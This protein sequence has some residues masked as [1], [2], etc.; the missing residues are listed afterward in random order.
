M[1]YLSI[2]RVEFEVVFDYVV[3]IV[4]F[5][6][7]SIVDFGYLLDLG[8]EGEQTCL[9]GF[10]IWGENSEADFGLFGHED[11]GLVA[12]S[13]EA[14]KPLLL[15]ATSNDGLGCLGHVDLFRAVYSE[16]LVG[17]DVKLAVFF[18]KS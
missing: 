5:N 3:Y 9:G 2:E 15:L 17:E 18:S 13:E 11:G 16:V 1:G 7:D 4:G 6:E 14:E 8:G 10:L 12:V